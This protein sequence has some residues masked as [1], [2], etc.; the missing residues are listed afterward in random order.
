MLE[1]AAHILNSKSV[2]PPALEVVEALLTS[3]QVARKEKLQYSLQELIG[4]WRLC[5][6][7]GTRRI[8]RK[9]GSFLKQGRYIPQFIK[10]ELTYTQTKSL[11]IDTVGTIENNINLGVFKLTLTGPVKFLA[12]KNILVFDF[13]ELKVNCLGIKLYD[14]YIRNGEAKETEFYTAKIS[15]QAFFV[16]FLVTKTAIAARGK[17]GGLALW[18]RA[19]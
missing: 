12:P 15:K 17:G 9:T 7:T 3:E 13:T 5:F 2:K 14:G 4:T 8:G 1:R 18:S 11:S 19:N 6:I 16:Y 10:I